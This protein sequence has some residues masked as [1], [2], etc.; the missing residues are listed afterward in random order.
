ME[1]PPSTSSTLLLPQSSQVSRLRRETHA[2]ELNLTLSR[3]VVYILTPKKK[4]EMGARSAI[5]LSE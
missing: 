3:S 1:L 5:C 4:V 2:S